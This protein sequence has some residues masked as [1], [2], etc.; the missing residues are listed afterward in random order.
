MKFTIPGVLV[1]VFLLQSC[2]LDPCSSKRFFIYSHEKLIEGVKERADDFTEKDWERKEAKMDQMA[3]ECYPKH[4]AEMTNDERKN[5]WIDYIHFNIK[6][7]GSNFWRELEK[8]SQEWPDEMGEDLGVVLDNP[9][10]DLKKLLK[11]VYGEDLNNAID[12][13]LGEFEKLGNKLKEWLG[14]KN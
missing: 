10:Q 6:R 14:D 9:E 4:S 5:F 1:L 13:V 12:E 3:S 7:H 8:D 11:E 2:S